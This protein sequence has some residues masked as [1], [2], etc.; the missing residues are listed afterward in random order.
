MVLAQDAI[1]QAVEHPNREKLI[2]KKLPDTVLCRLLG[3]SGLG[4]ED[5]HLLSPIGTQLGPSDIFSISRET[6]AGIQ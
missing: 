3:L 6:N 4:W 2:P 1:Q 5:Q